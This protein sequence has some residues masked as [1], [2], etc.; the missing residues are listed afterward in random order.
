MNEIAR[1]FPCCHNIF[2]CWH[3]NKN[4]LANCKTRF[5]DVEWQKFMEWWNMFVSSTSVELFDGALGVFKKTYLGTHPAAWQYVNMMWMPHKER[6]VA[7]YIDEF[8]H[9]GSASTSKVEG[10]HHVIKLYVRVG[11]LHLLTLTKRLGLMLV[12]QRVE[13]NAAIEK[14]R[15]HKAHR[16]DHSCFKDLIYKVS[17]FAL[18]KLLQQLKHVEKG[19]TWGTTMLCAVHEIVGVALSSL[20][21]QLSGNRISNCLA[22]HSWVMAVGQKPLDPSKCQCSCVAT[23]T[24]V[25]TKFIHADDDNYRTTS[26]Q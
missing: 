24:D 21:L 23:R 13:L 25:T 6:V 9:F 8:P 22:W 20:H 7:C 12:N 5:F 17:N 1:V 10:N 16:F 15:V 26:I 11:T 2:Y 18:D 19:G 14:Q 4:I 3:I